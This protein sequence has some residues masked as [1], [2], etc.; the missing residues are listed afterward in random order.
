MAE[1]EGLAPVSG[2]TVR[3]TIK[4]VVEVKGNGLLYVGGL[5]SRQQKNG[6]EFLSGS[7]GTAWRTLAFKNRKRSEASADFNLYLAPNKI[8]DYTNKSKDQAASEPQSTE[9]S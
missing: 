8:V 2:Q 5:W 7:A 3:R 4:V 1:N 6:D 9:N